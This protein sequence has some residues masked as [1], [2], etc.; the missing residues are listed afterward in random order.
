M[1]T[2]YPGYLF[3]V[4]LFVMLCWII[5]CSGRRDAEPGKPGQGEKTT[6]S[7][8]VPVLMKM[9][10]PAENSTYR[11]R[12]EIKVKLVPEDGNDS[13]DSIKV[14]FDG[15]EVAVIKND[16]W[17]CTVDA[18]ANGMTGRRSVKAVAYSSNLTQ[19]VTRFVTVMSDTA[20]AKYGYRVVSSYP[21]DRQAFTQ[22]LFYDN[23]IL[24]E[25]TGQESGSTLREVELETG[26]VLRLLNLDPALFGEGITMYQDRI[27][28]VTWTNK[29]G[30]IYSKSD[31]KLLNRIFYQTEGWGLT[32]IGDKIVM[33]DGSN[34][35]HFHDPEMFNLL[36]RLEVY[37]NEKKVDQLN[38][39]E[40]INGEI[41]ANIWMT[42][43]I[44]R[45]DPETG[46]VNSYVNLSGLFPEKERR[47][48]NADVLNGIA[49]DEAGKRIFVTGK[50]WPR[51]YEIIVT[52]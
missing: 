40:Y 16:P 34:I 21:H 50:R 1:K 18:S 3:N 13:F 48:T 14:F 51:L 8:P 12:E 11:L 31:F 41:W 43:L 52:E 9:S 4:I 20:P 27:Y 19:S 36:S 7:L 2:R 15:K 23:G 5:S 29:V 47:E 42:D 6:G 17:E 37:D 33:S 24:Y 30:F 38:E 49:Y 39:L 25:G 10:S 26:K 46:K 22:G 28:Q 45:I 32:T 35:L 44:A